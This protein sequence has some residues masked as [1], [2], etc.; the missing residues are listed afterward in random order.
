M[1][2][3]ARAIEV[4]A[5]VAAILIVV[6][7]SAFAATMS[8]TAYLLGLAVAFFVMMFDGAVDRLRGDR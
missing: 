2:R 8:V 4:L 7:V 6:A 1:T 3:S 5:W